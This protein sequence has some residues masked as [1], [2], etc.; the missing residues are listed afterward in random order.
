[1]TQ[2]PAPRES[3]TAQVL[4]FSAPEF[5][6]F[7]TSPSLDRLLHALWC[8]A[9]NKTAV[10]QLAEAWTRHKAKLPKNNALGQFCAF[11]DRTSFVVTP[12]PKHHDRENEA[13]IAALLDVINKVLGP[14]KPLM[15]GDACY[16]FPAAEPICQIYEE[17]FGDLNPIPVITRALKAVFGAADDRD[18]ERRR[19]MQ[20]VQLTQPLRRLLRDVC[21]WV[22]STCERQTK[23]AVEA[24]LLLSCG[25]EARCKGGSLAPGDPRT[26]Y[27]ALAVDK[28]LR[29]VTLT[30]WFRAISD[31][32][33]DDGLVAGLNVLCRFSIRESYK[34]D[35]QTK[36]KLTA[37]GFSP[38]SDHL[39]ALDP[40]VIGLC[41][42]LR[43]M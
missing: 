3:T 40:D 21:K 5:R 39:D 38:P 41:S 22:S 6:A 37:L 35:R 8:H 42:S 20:I 23:T 10:T 24:C 4:E 14:A 43:Q 19:E 13:Q 33:T 31:Y 28:C 26:V 34:L 18:D 11:L 17:Q 16:Y 2:S 36:N 25:L 30:K 7:D 1:M 27:A 9:G 29:N 15:K 32:D 12:P